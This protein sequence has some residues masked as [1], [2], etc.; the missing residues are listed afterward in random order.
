MKVFIYRVS[1]N[2]WAYSRSYTEDV[3]KYNKFSEGLPMEI[4]AYKS[5][6]LKAPRFK[7]Y[8]FFVL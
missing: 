5:A 7:Q 2:R 8:T 1:G 4:Q 3:K 6:P